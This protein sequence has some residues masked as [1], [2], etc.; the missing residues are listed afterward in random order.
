MIQARFEWRTKEGQTGSFAQSW[1]L[2]KGALEVTAVDYGAD[3]AEGI[4]TDG[5]I[6]V[7]VRNNGNEMIRDAR[8][9]ATP[10]S[11]TRS[12]N[13]EFTIAELAPGASARAQVP[14]VITTDGQCQNGTKG[15]VNI[16]G[17]YSNGIT[18]VALAAAAPYT[19]G[20][21]MTETEKFEGLALP[22]PDG[23]GEVTKTIQVNGSGALKDLSIYV[24]IDHTYIGDLQIHLVSPT[25]KSALLHNR[26]G[27]S[28][29][30]LVQRWG[31][32]GVEHPELNQ[33]AGDEVRGEWKLVIK[34]LASQDGGALQDVEL[35]LRYW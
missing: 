21:L 23:S 8:V 1:P 9:G 27:G 13:G 5:Q 17:T 18:R 32:G 25:G 3:G 26:T 24:K 11:C 4:G 7:T 30:Q 6:F 12:V 29:D 31:R 34:D 35:T 14:F 10:G 28:T 19:V 2:I 20:A 15:T 16:A 33:L 22:I